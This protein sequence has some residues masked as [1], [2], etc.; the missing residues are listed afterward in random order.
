MDFRDLAYFETVAEL[1]HL[2]QAAEKLCRTQSALSKCVRRLEEELGMSLF[3]RRGRGIVLTAAGA[4]LYDRAK[5]LRKGMESAKKQLLD[6]A[7]G[8]TGHVRLGASSTMAELLLPEL[9]S[10]F[11][12]TAPNVTL[13]LTIG[14]N[15]VLRD[16]LKAGHIDLMLGPLEDNETTFSASPLFDDAVVI[17]AGPDH[18]IFSLHSNRMGHDVD[19]VDTA[20]P[21]D[22]KDA[23]RNKARS[24]PSEKRVPDSIDCAALS[25]Y[26]WVLPPPM[27]STRRWLETRLREQGVTLGTVQVETNSILLLPQLIVRNQLLSLLSRRNLGPGRPG[28][29]LREVP[30]SGMTMQRR[31]G[32][33]YREEAYMTPATICLLNLLRQEGSSAFMSSADTAS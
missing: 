8:I 19:A 28:H 17:V 32:V 29:P 23:R 1:G 12:S 2:G 11:L 25:D 16:S 31:F 4:L 33:L 30:I 6:Y 14:L 3:E 7:L 15:D 21:T 22:A 5:V 13:Q 9:S 26:R 18:P 20:P 24:Q 10:R 27:V